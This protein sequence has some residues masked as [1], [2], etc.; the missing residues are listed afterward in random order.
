MKPVRRII[1]GHAPD[2]GS[3]F[4]DVSEVEPLIGTTTRLWGVWGWDEGIDTV[5]VAEQPDSYEFASLFPP[6]GGVRVTVIEHPPHRDP[7]LDPYSNDPS[8]ADR[9][10][11]E[12]VHEGGHLY[13]RE[14]RLHSTNS[15]DIAF[16]ISGEIEFHQDD[17]AFVTLRQGDCMIINGTRHHWINRSDEPCRIGEVMLGANRREP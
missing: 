7:N 1:T 15:I 4:H 13:E 16:V 14:G 9:R 11:M 6:V 10:I 5:P 2:G 12:L 3:V 17:D 8:D